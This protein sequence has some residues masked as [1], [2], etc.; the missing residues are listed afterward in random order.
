MAPKRRSLRWTILL[1]GLALGVLVFVGATRYWS[2]L[3]FEPAAEA[4]ATRRGALIE[5]EIDRLGSDHPWAGYYYF[6]DGLGANVSLSLAPESGFVFE[7][8]GCVGVYDRNWGAVTATAER[9]ELS[10]HYPNEREGFQGLDPDFVPVSWGDRHYLVPTDRME[11]FCSDVNS[12]WE[13]RH[14]AHGTYLLRCGDEER[15]TQGLP[16]VPQKYRELLLRAPI[17]ASVIE[18]LRSWKDEDGFCRARVKL[19]VGSE[20]GVVPRMPMSL[21]AEHQFRL[22]VVDEVNAGSCI[23]EV[24]GAKGDSATPL[25][26]WRFSS[27]V[28]QD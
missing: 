7:W 26:G 11:R 28:W 3:R 12:G 6:G 2:S 13:P 8:W 1:A 17:E 5:R 27:S 14:H 21:V 25:V 9:I 24:E 20:Q 15:A 22:L 18:I 4:E 16:L 23:A 19:D 10:F